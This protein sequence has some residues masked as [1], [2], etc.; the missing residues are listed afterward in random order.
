MYKLYTPPNVL[1]NMYWYEIQMLVKRFIQQMEDEKKA[2]EEESEVQRTEM[3]E[4]RNS[5]R[6]P[7]MPKMDMPNFDSISRGFSDSLSKV[8][9]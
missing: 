7:E 8:G 1:D 6:T 9:L 4:Y 2:Q 5:Y 3:E